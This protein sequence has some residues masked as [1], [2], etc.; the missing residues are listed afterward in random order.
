MTQTVISRLINPF[1]DF[2]LHDD[3]GGLAH[4]CTMYISLFYGPGNKPKYFV[5]IFPMGGCLGI[6]KTLAITDNVRKCEDFFSKP[7]DDKL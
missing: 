5:G 7:C 2:S 1:R 4:Q 3:G 6:P